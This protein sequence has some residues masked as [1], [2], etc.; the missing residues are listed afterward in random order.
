VT[1]PAGWGDPA[2]GAPASERRV[3]RAVEETERLGAA[4]AA[5]LEPGDVLL[6]SGP[7]GSGK[8][9][10]VAGLARGLGVTGRVRSPS[11][12]LLNEYGGRLRLHHLDLYR[13]SGPEAEGLGIEELVDDGV[14]AVEWGEKLPAG[15]REGALTL[16]FE[17]LSENE[18]AVTATAAG[19]RG[20]ELLA[21]WRRV[22]PPG[23]AARAPAE[24]R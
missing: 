20:L 4:L 21:A 12:T 24:A 3:T 18:R 7:L 10:F 8:T 23:A 22:A 5:H 19:G 17:I 2:P 13:L 14:L 11:F 1:G 15:L 6:L 9:R 16:L